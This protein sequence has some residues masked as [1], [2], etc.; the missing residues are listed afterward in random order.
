MDALAPQTGFA[1]LRWRR[2]TD[3]DEVGATHVVFLILLVV[4]CYFLGLDNLSIRG[5]ESRWA[6]VAQEMARTGDWIVPRQQ[7]QPF[8]SR[9]PLGSWLMALSAKVTGGWSAWAIRLPSAAALLIT[10][11]L[12][13]WYGL[14]LL[15]R[16]AAFAAAAAFAT[17][18]EILQMGRVGETDMVFTLLLSAALLIWHRLDCRFGCRLV[19]WMVGYALAALAALAKGPQAPTYFIAVT[20]IYLASQCRWRH[21][22]GW[23]HAAGIGV[24]LLIVG[25]WLVPF[26]LRTDLASVRQIWF[27]DSAFRFQDLTVANALA[28]AVTYPLETLGCTSPWSL[29]LV[30]AVTAQFRVNGAAWP[31]ALRFVI[32]ALAVTYPT[33]WLTPGGL[34][35]Y[36]MPL[37]PCLAL[38]I[39]SAIE[40]CTTLKPSAGLL[41]TG[42]LV[43]SALALA[44]IAI[45]LALFLFNWLP[46]PLP[47]SCWR[48]PV[49]IQVVVALATAAL[50]VALW[51]KTWHRVA[52]HR[53]IAALALFA[54]VLYAGPIVQNLAHRNGRAESAIREL[55]ICRHESLASCGPAHHLFAYHVGVPIRYLPLD[56]AWPADWHKVDYFCYWWR[57]DQ[58]RMTLPFPTEDVATI[59]MERDRFREPATVVIVVRRVPQPKGPGTA[60]VPK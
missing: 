10:T 11:L 53:A 37:Y 46:L 43:R 4:S 15:T 35:R 41:R 7:G 58:P 33:C 28:H 20:S 51:P 52:L 6:T 40:H 9:P 27:G 48:Q 54:G 44:G 60:Q 8:L 36:F 56:R 59:S 13:Y 45:A 2:L 1:L 16:T 19:T 25:A 50:C 14:R 49:A 12:I 30:L 22:F 32:I 18:G 34:S 21:L 38:L 42:R 23:R 31:K 47:W 3:L 39:G 29:I 26:Y 57:S 55:G 5:E 17:M 24:F